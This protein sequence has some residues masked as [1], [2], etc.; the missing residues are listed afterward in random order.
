MANKI[1]FPHGTSATIGTQP[2]GQN[3]E[4]I[5]QGDSSW[6]IFRNSV[7]GKNDGLITTAIMGA[8]HLSIGP[9]LLLLRS[10]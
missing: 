5:K 8:S 10:P 6:V 7:W 3:E 1:F 2:R 9:P 4:L